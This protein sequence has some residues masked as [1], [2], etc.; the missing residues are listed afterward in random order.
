[1]AA[2]LAAYFVLA[3][4]YG[5]VEPLGEAP[6]EAPHFTVIRYLAEH[7][8][9]PGPAEHEAFQPPLYY[10]L[11]AALTLPF[12]LKPYR[13]VANADFDLHAPQA[14]KNLLLHGRDECFPYA[15]WAKAWHLLRVVSSLLG[16][17]TLW[18]IWK[19]LEAISPSEEVALLG[20]AM[21]AFAPGF[22]F[23][24]AAL[25]NDNLA[26]ALAALFFLVS[27]RFLDRPTPG[28]AALMGVLW[29]LGVMSK[30]SLLLLGLPWAVFL[31]WAAWRSPERL[32]KLVL[33]AV[34][35]FVPLILISGWWFWRNW[36]LY[37]DP[38]G[39]PLVAQ[40][41]ALRQG[42]LTLGILWWLLRGLYRSWWLSYVGLNL[43]GWLYAAL[44]I[45]PLGALVGWARRSDG[46]WTRRGRG[47]ALL[48]LVYA[49][50]VFAAL[51]RWTAMVLGTSQARLLYPALPAFALFLGGGWARLASGRWRR[52][53]VGATVFLLILAAWTPWGVIR[54][55]YARPEY[56]PAPP[57]S[58]PH[59]SF[60]SIGLHE[61][62]LSPGPW[63]A[64]GTYDLWLTWRSPEAP[65]P[66]LWLLVKLVDD[67][68]RTV[69]A[70]DGSP[71]A[72]R[73]TTDCW[74]P[75]TFIPSHHRLRLPASLP[76]GRY[77]L[78]IGIHPPGKWT[79]WP[80]VVDGKPVGEVYDVGTV[81]V[82]RGSAVRKGR[83]PSGWLLC[84]ARATASADERMV[85]R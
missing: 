52:V 53:G 64:G 66:D 56:R 26:M 9:L 34:V 74:P 84:Y 2:V 44:G 7:R 15:S 63:T 37:H 33:W 25:N 76:A 81:E 45:V 10:A 51:L 14:T 57:V 43:P 73:D 22:I 69:W 36:R 8:S 70:K 29:G 38:M 21:T 5:F 23:S 40:T 68:G 35:G 32:R 54:H 16:L 47:L 72:G 61:V 82:K 71:T 59:V 85:R 3:M 24:T 27:V 78:Q 30:V 80:V 11:G 67:D 79:W 46:F 17:V 31:L 19:L 41:N 65:L 83:E 42:G 75:G 49:L 13:V 58:T 18:A 20:V 12:D 48:L 28:R 62:H 6:D 55:T 1:M 39:W 50:A 60:G 77:R 4:T